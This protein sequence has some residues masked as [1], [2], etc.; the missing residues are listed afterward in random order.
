MTRSNAAVE[1]YVTFRP[2][3]GEELVADG[4]SVRPVAGGVDEFRQ[5]SQDGS[6]SGEKMVPANGISVAAVVEI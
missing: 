5:V 3:V 1:S 6:E 2:E 4:K